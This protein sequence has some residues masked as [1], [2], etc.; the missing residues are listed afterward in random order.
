MKTD[1]EQVERKKDRK[2]KES[3]KTTKKL[4]KLAKALASGLSPVEQAKSQKKFQKL[5]A[6]AEKLGGGAEAEEAAQPPASH[7]PP[8]R[9]V[10]A[11]RAV[12]M[13]LGLEP[14]SSGELLRRQAR[15]HRFQACDQAPAEG[16][17]TLQ[18]LRHR[19]A[20]AMGTSE[21]LEKEYLR[22]TSAPERASVRPPRVLEASLQLVKRRWRE[23][24]DYAHACNQL[25]AIRQDLTVQHVRDELAVRVY[26]THARIALE[27]QDHAEFNQCQTTLRA[28]YAAGVPGHEHEFAA[29]RVLYAL[30]TKGDVLRE[31][32]DIPLDVRLHQDFAHVLQICR[33]VWLH[34]YKGFFSLHEVTPGMGPFLLD[35]LVDDV[36][37]DALAAMSKAYD[38][39]AELALSFV[40]DQLGFSGAD[41]IKQCTK[42]A[43][44]AGL[45]VDV[46]SKTLRMRPRNIYP[47]CRA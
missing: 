14:G 26:E 44:D 3:R 35:C 27:A 8:R 22:L 46:E 31:F 15:A 18:Q 5:L 37:R 45:E 23:A 1:K 30:V 34:D 39:S 25:K 43:R 16:A 2:A 21:A 24:A 33:C 6:K 7:A 29:Y 38:H 17:A 42:F 19:D 9:A 32:R 20:A 41:N 47:S 12:C 40:A 4:K 36:R 10:R 13:S 28:L 11:G